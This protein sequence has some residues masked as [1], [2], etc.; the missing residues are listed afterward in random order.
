MLADNRLNENPSWDDR[1]LA[2]QLKE[3][4]ELDLDFS[5][6][7]TGSEMGEID[8]RIEGLNSLTVGGKDPADSLPAPPVSHVGDLWL[9]RDHRVYCGSA[10]E[11][12]AY[13]ALMQGDKATMVFS[14]PPSNLPIEGNVSGLGA[15]RH[16]DFMMAA[17]EM[18]ESEF[19]AFLKRAFSLMA[20][21]SSA[22]S[23]HFLCMDWRHMNET[24]TA[25]RRVY[26]PLKN[27]C[28]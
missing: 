7:L 27:L 12:A 5:L 28:I 14:D 2:E 23:L 21:H 18:S 19:I 3:L 1:L 24:L 6:E 20:S 11:D 9:L 13:A 15:I 10:L 8:L 16:K 25:G 4:S 22:G 17:G 26:A